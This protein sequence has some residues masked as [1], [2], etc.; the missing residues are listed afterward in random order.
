MKYILLLDLFSYHKKVS[1]FLIYLYIFHIEIGSSSISYRGDGKIILS[2]H[3][4]NTCRI[5]QSA[6]LKPLALLNF[7]QL[8]VTNV[9]FSPTSNIFGLASK[10]KTITIWDVYATNNSQT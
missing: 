6:K 1:S 4:D 10:D 9:C 2:S 8:Q 3:W 5:L 7:H